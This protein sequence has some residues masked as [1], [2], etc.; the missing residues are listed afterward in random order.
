MKVN[1]KIILFIFLLIILISS[2]NVLASFNFVEQF[3]VEIK[4]IDLNKEMAYYIKDSGE[5]HILKNGLIDE[6]KNLV[7][8]RVKITALKHDKYLEVVNYKL[9]DTEKNLIIG[10]AYYNGDNYYFVSREN[11]LYHIDSGLTEKQL[12]KD[13]LIRYKKADDKSIAVLDF[14]VIK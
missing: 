6:M 2:L 11:D 5:F 10:E 3:E 14:V 9:S 8:H 13:L 12:N 7:G 1:I 4:S